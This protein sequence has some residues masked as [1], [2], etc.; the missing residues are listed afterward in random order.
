MNIGQAGRNQGGGKGV[1]C[2]YVCV[3]WGE[4]ALRG[5]TKK[6]VWSNNNKRD[7]KDKKV[8]HVMGD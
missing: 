7:I 6:V 5:C 1:F 3:R 2:V 8:A 4:F